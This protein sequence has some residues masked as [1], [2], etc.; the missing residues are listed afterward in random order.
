[1]PGVDSTDPRALLAHAVRTNQAW[2]RV[3]LSRLLPPDA[4]HVAS[5]TIE[6][7]GDVAAY[8]D[9][10]RVTHPAPL[11]LAADTE[12]QAQDL[13]DLAQKVNATLD[14]DIDQQPGR[15]QEP[16]VPQLGL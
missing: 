8:R 13:R 11:G 9:R 10:W 15:E 2:L 7:L 4:D 3:V 5:P 14:A 16:A 6:L 1:M 12:E